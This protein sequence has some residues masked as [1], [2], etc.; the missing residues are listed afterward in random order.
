MT[1]TPTDETTRQMR[2]IRVHEYGDADVLTYERV[3]RP[4]PADDELLVRVRAA[5]VNPIDWMVREGYADEALDPS[6][7]YVP[8]WDL[9]GTVEAVGDDVTAF[10]PGDEVFGLVGMPDPGR[11]YA[12]YA[13]VPA[14]DVVPKPESLDHTAA[15]GVPMVA[16]TAWRGLFEAGNLTPDQRLLVHAAAGGVGHMAVQFADEVGAHVV[17]TAS[18]RNEAF[19]RDL[20]VDEF[21]D[22]RERAFETAVDGVDLVL[23]AVGGDTLDRSVDVLNQNGRIVTLPE[24]PGDDVVARARSE[25]NGTVDWFS[26]EPDPDALARIRDRIDAGQVTPTVS[27]TWSLADAGAAHQRSQTGHVRGKLVLRTDQ[28]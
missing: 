11:T 28:R 19:L 15:A 6:L 24:P 2:A 1:D 21:V 17:G 5:G 13:A 25:R 23:D 27:E 16:L 18:G 7:P 9:S 20:G 14:D 22:Y 10:G 3:P 12:E 8:G 26:V 4:Q